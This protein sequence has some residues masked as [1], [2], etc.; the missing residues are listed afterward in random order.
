VLK[1]G[2]EGVDFIMLKYGI[3]EMIYENQEVIDRIIDGVKE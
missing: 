2:F 3:P 1:N